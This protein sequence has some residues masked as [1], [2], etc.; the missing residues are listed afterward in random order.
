VADQNNKNLEKGFRY[1][2]AFGAIYIIWGTT[3][4]A[5]KIGIEDFPPFIMASIRYFMAGVLLLIIC[6]MKG[7]NI[8]S[9]DVA[10]NLLLGAFIMTFGQAIAF[11]SEKYISSGLT[12][13]FGSLLPI[14]Y[15]I[16]DTRHW[17]N[18]RGSKLTIASIGLG[19]VGI[20][21]LFFSPSEASEKHTGV[22]SFIASVVTIAG[23]FCWAAGSLY[24]KYH[25]SSGSLLENVG[26]Q[27]IG[28]MIC[29]GIIVLI[30][31]EWRNF[32]IHFISAKAWF[33]VIYL[34]IAGSIV[35]LIALY[36]LLA[37]RPAAI[38]GTYAYVNPVIA[39]IL[40]FLIANEKIKPV[41][42]FGMVLILIAAY[43]ANQVKFKTAE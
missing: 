5:I 27:L 16:T 38:V 36:W 30:T 26:W 35:A 4:L 41:Q 22:L 19:L 18:Y 2:L 40:G 11:W 43:M 8:F 20:V 17:N 21:I 9:K 23:C 3:Y 14:C 39:V 1:W 37:R 7:E 10:R 32:N 31:G 42:I 13:V 28:G 34:A 15:I 12:A 29:C 33:A 25:K 6:S 24:Y